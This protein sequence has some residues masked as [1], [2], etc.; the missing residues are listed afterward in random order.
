MKMKKITVDKRD[1]VIFNY[2]L[3]ERSKG[4]KLHRLFDQNCVDETRNIL[5]GWGVPFIIKEYFK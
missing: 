4:F 5:T 1:K 3:K 2:A